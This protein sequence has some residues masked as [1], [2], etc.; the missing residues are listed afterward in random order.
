MRS[1]AKLIL[2]PIGGCQDGYLVSHQSTISKSWWRC[3]MDCCM[4]Q[5]ENYW[6]T[7]RG[8]GALTFL[9]SGMIRKLKHRDLSNSLMRYSLAI[10]KLKRPCSKWSGFA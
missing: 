4:S 3:K 8:S 6:D 5:L 2:N 9:S 1:G 10:G 7:A